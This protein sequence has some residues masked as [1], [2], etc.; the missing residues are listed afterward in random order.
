MSEPFFSLEDLTALQTINDARSAL[1]DTR[2]EALMRQSFEDWV[3]FFADK[4]K[5]SMG[6]LE[7]YRAQVIEIFK[8]RNLVVHNGARVTQIPGGSG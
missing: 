7:P 1:I 4:P 8:R 5:L 2:V 3:K 6:Y